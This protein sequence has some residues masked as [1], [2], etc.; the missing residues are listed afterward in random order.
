VSN[1]RASIHVRMRLARDFASRAARKSDAIA[2]KSALRAMRSRLIANTVRSPISRGEM[3]IQTL[4]A[5]WQ[6]ELETGGN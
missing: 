2:E 5:S 1:T 4:G 3:R 6:Q